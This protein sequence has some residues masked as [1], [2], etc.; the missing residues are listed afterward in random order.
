MPRSVAN[1]VVEALLE[2]GH[3]LSELAIIA[4]VDK[5]HISRLK[6]GKTSIDSYSVGAATKLA[7]ALNVELLWLL[8]E[9][10]P[11]NANDATVPRVQGTGREIFRRIAPD[12]NIPPDVIEHLMRHPQYSSL[13]FDAPRY[14]AAWWYDKARARMR[15]SRLLRE[16]TASA[17]RSR[18]ARKEDERAAPSSKRKPV[19]GDED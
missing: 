1:R 11:K 19:A 12:L 5:A 7:R 13:A 10:G 4:E 8:E 2:S 18:R 16:K 3:T 9:K 6:N 15:R 14:D 17:Q